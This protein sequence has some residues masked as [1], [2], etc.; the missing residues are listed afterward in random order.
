LY[1]IA[2]AG[3]NK[4]SAEI[5]WAV[6]NSGGM[7]LAPAFLHFVIN[8]CGYKRPLVLKT[9]YAFAIV[10][11]LLTM[12]GKMDFSLRF[13]KYGFY[14]ASAHAP[15]YHAEAMLWILIVLYGHWLLFSAIKGADREKQIQIR[16][17]AVAMLIGFVSGGT[18]HWLYVY[19][20]DLHPAWNIF[21]A[22]YCLLVTYSIFRHKLLGLDFV[23]RKG[24]AY[25]LLLSIITFFYFLVL[26]ILEN[27]FQ[28]SV[29]YQPVYSISVLAM[30]I[31]LGEPLRVKIQHIIDYSFFKG[32]VKSLSAE[33]ELLH[34][35]IVKQDRMKAVATLAAGMA[36]EIKNPLTSIKT[37]A[38][39]LPIKY[40]DP[41]F[42]KKF[43]RIV[44]D[45]VDRVNNIVKQLLEF[46][47]PSELQVR[48]ILASDLLDQTLSLLSNNLLE[49]G[50]E[51]TKHFDVYAMI[52]GD[53][54]QLKQAFLNL[55]LNGTQ[56]MKSGGNL[57]VSCVTQPNDLVRI[58]FVDSGCGIPKEN[59]PH[60][61]DPFYTTR[62]EG[63][64]LGLAI[65][66]SIITKHGGKIEIQSEVGKGTTV[67]VFL[68]SRD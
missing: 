57:T 61:F 68:K 17:L 64:G 23:I 59:L 48:P 15:L 44:V 5:Y 1:L 12:I 38:E 33:R 65:V 62:E 9:A 63:T 13:V 60:I 3:P 16:Y 52:Q 47:K 19:R 67:N 45:E 22:V 50:I 28:K 34:N 39:Y 4:Q 58:S 30:A 36:H 31:L 40:D 7:I 49:N 35:E 56:S 6:A 46:S 11:V 43:S 20:V 2:L 25:S 51:L 26:V 21:I 53:K 54:N 29:G 24:L 10:F 32:D 18:S 27:V 66:H 55:L 42:R 8:F 14:Y 41:E 37:F